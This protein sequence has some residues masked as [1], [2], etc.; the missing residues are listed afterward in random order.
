[1]PGAGPL[2]GNADAAGEAY[3]SV[4]DEQFAVRAIVQLREVI[5]VRLVI[6]AYLYSRL[7]HFLQIG[8]LHLIAADPVEQ[9][10]HLDSSVSALCQRV[11]KLLAD[12]AGPIDISFKSDRASSR[13]DCAQHRREDLVSVQ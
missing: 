11:G 2:I 10:V 6:A 9:H 12:A 13:A 4:D 5:P 7:L 1:L 8:L 3:F